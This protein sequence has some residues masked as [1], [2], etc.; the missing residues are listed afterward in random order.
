MEAEIL[1]CC[2]AATP[3]QTRASQSIPAPKAAALAWMLICCYR[4]QHGSRERGPADHC[5]LD[6]I[7]DYGNGGGPVPNGDRDVVAMVQ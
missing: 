5:L 1:F 7:G 3:R 6:V 2:S 4:E